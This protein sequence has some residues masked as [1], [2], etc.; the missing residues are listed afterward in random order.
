M[1]LGFGPTASLQQID[2]TPALGPDVYR[3]GTVGK[4]TTPAYAGR[5]ARAMGENNTEALV[6][7]SL[8]TAGERGGAFARVNAA[9]IVATSAVTSITRSR[10]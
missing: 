7:R 1:L 5:F 2:Q 10:A 3:L 9:P 6:W 4:P 8:G